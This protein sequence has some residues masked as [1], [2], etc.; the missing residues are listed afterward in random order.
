MH[1][2]KCELPHSI[3]SEIWAWTED[4]NIWITDSYIAVKEKPKKY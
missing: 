3:I 2:N 1:S 4:R